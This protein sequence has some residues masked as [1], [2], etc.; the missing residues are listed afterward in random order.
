MKQHFFE[1]CRRGGF[2]K[3]HFTDGYSNSASYDLVK[4][5]FD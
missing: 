1:N 5:K 3:V 4:D 2:S